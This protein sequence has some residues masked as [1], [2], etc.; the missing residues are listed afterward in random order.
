MAGHLQSIRHCTKSMNYSIITGVELNSEM[1]QRRANALGR[2]RTE[3]AAQRAALYH[4][5]SFVH[6]ERER[7]LMPSKLTHQEF[8]QRVRAIHGDKYDYSRIV[9]R[10]TKY[11]VLIGCP[12]HGWF[13]QVVEIHLYNKSGCPNLF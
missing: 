2:G 4:R 7:F 12:Y 1:S 13:E 9:Y 5:R 10:G 11:K 6:K 8:I 3:S